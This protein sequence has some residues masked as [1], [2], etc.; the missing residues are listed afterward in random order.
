MVKILVKMS[1]IHA[2][3]PHFLLISWEEILVTQVLGSCHVCGRPGS[4]S[5]LSAPASAGSQG[6]NQ[7]MGALNDYLSMS[8]S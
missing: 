3:D 5:Q 2:R 6:V 7:Q 4:G 1:I 8:L